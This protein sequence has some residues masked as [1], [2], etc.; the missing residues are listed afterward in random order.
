MLGRAP[1]FRQGEALFA[2]GFTPTPVDVQMR[3]RLTV[4]GGH[5][6]AVPLST[7]TGPS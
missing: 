4:E 5:D 3:A 1:T 2:G 7:P 6:V